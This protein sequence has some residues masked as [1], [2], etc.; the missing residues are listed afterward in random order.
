MNLQAI[1]NE[2]ISLELFDQL[3]QDQVDRVFA[4]EVVDICPEFLGFVGVYKYLSVMIP[5]HFT[6]VDLGCGFNP[7]S[8]YF[9]Q[10]K[11]FVAVDNFP[12][13]ER[14]KSPNCDFYQM[15][16]EDFIRKHLADFCLEETFAI[17][18]FVP[19]WGADNME[20]VRN[21]FKNVYTYYPHERGENHTVKPRG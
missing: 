10:H 13:A 20:L 17:C 11:R 19:P 4:G 2:K 12:R 5:Y 14:F 16:I 3:P 8:F 9:T 15:S 18:S 21:N 7:Q 1:D 6:V